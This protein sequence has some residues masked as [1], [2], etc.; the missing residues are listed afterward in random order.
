M[1]LYEMHVNVPSIK[2]KKKNIKQNVE[3]RTPNRL[4]Q[5]RN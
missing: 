1:I 2:K 4:N 3:K 5:Y